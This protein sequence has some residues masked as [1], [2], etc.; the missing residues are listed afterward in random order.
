MELQHDCPREGD[1]VIVKISGGPLDG[2][3]RCFDDGP[4]E[5]RWCT[6]LTEKKGKQYIECYELDSF[7]T[8]IVDKDEDSDYFGALTPVM[9]LYYKY[10][11]RR[12][13][14][15]IDEDGRMSIKPI[16]TKKKKKNK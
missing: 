14:D 10:V 6:N 2:E 15:E 8:F 11:G 1:V 7:G 5:H 13:V 12:E 16:K 3:V 4:P 9:E